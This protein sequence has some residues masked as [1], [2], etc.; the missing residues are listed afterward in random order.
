MHRCPFHDLAEANP[1]IVC[2]VHRGLIEGALTELG[3]GLSVEA[4]EIFPRPNVCV[5]R[6]AARS[7]PKEAVP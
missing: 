3:S 4:L 2:A 7:D 5:A 6:L 1:R